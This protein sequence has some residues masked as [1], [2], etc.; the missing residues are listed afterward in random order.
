MPDVPQRARFNFEVPV[1]L[2]TALDLLK[3]KGGQ[4]RLVG[5]CV[6]DALL[7]TRPKDF[8]IEV[9]GLELEAIIETLKSIGKTDLVGKSF[10]VVKLWRNGSEFDFSVP[11]KELKSGAGHRGFDIQTDIHLDPKSAL[12]RR[13]FTI[14]ALQYDPDTEEIVDYFG[15][16]ED[17]EK[18]I[19]RHVSSAFAEDPLRALRAVQFAGRFGLSLD[20]RTAELCRSMKR[21]FATLAK[22]RIWGE[23]EKWATQSTAPSRGLA[24][25]VDCGWI[26]F[27]PE[28]NA[29]A[30]LPQDPE[31]HPEGDA[32]T[33][34]QHCV[35]ALV[36]SE[37]WRESNSH[38]RAI[39]MFG[40]LCHDLG[41]ARCTRFAEKNGKL[42]WI[43]PGHDQESGW[44]SQDFLERIGAPLSL[45]EKVKPFV[46]NHHFLNSFSNGAPSDASLRR[47]SSRIHP[48]TTYE[49]LEVM[50]ADHLGR[51]RLLSEPQEK[52]L[53]EFE[54][55]IEVLA[56]RDA[57]QKP[58]LLGRHLIEQGH[59]PGP[60]F[61]LILDKAYD[62]QLE[63]VFDDLKGALEWAR[64]ESWGSS[65]DS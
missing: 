12:K 20:S 8:D 57:A 25:L 49:L 64:A 38:Q 44:L 13:D 31:W 48:A 15:G 23:W 30:R 6:R 63:G 59:S 29:L 37:A 7:G 14:N 10:A 27:F 9:Y 33:H 5:G 28:L 1:N 19:L 32:L 45:A 18:G 16:R 65:S 35:D 22:E 55:R 3:K 61:K 50:R 41:K 40:V 47:L 39:L 53:G 51:P 56:V 62:A 58:I 4:C 26:T 52:R 21:E 43:S 42:R 24:V 2:R 36:Q 34:T 46:E 60:D 11:R 17:L 54:C